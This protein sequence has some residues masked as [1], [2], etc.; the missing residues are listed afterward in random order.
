MKF[1]P[2]HRKKSAGGGNCC[3]KTC[4]NKKC[5]N[6]ELSFHKVPKAGSA[7]IAR[8]N[9]F[10]KIEMVDKRSEW[11]RLLKVKDYNEDLLVCSLHFAAKN[12]FFPGMYILFL[13][14]N[15]IE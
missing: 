6:L 8:K 12:Y 3:V 5:K 7:K 15:T 11:L 14:T 4:N 1:L 2:Q 10:G 9:L 13:F